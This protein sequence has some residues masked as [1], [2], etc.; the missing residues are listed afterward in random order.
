MACSHPHSDDTRDGHAH[1]HGGHSHA[2]EDA[3]HHA[4]TQEVGLGRAEDHHHVQAH[5]LATNLAEAQANQ[6]C[7]RAHA[8]AL[9]RARE[10]ENGRYNLIV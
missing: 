3:N 7:V 9:R 1:T 2:T 8:C 6:R 4:A 10:T 5:S